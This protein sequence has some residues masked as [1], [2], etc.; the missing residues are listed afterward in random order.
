M[1]NA[2]CVALA[3]GD[4][5]EQN[6]ATVSSYNLLIEALDTRRQELNISCNE[7]DELA[8]TALGYFGKCAGDS[9]TKKLGWKSTF[10]IARRL[11]LRL[12]FEIDEAAT[13]ETLAEACQ[14]E[15]AHVRTGNHSAPVSDR[16]VE[17]ALRHMATCYSWA[18]IVQAAS[19]ARKTI[20][21]EKAARKKATA[22]LAPKNHD[23][24]SSPAATAY[25]RGMLTAMADLGV[26]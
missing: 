22:V 7:L 14:R 4:R 8:G 17:R 24:R 18:E 26:R 5:N 2:R 10:P 25:D 19:G 9:R 3:S 6:Y 12:V 13:A 21:A 16:V 1:P 15:N 23:K 11:G 20:A